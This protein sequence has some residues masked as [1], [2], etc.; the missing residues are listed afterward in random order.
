MGPRGVVGKGT[1]RRAALSKEYETKLRK[2]SE[3]ALINGSAEY[4]FWYP[5]RPK[6]CIQ[7]HVFRPNVTKR[8]ISIN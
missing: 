3:A 7:M 6:T 4:H 5:A 1:D 8:I 2:Y